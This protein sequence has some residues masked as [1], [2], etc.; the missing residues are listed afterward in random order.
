MC[1][2]VS[3]AVTGCDE[4]VIE[5][6][7]SPGGVYRPDQGCTVAEGAL[8]CPGPGETVPDLRFESAGNPGVL[9]D[10]SRG[11]LSNLRVTCG[12]SACGTGSLTAHAAL[13]WNTDP[14]LPQRAASFSHPFSPAPD[15]MGHTV[16]FSVYIEELTVPMHAQIGVIF[17]FWRWVAWAPLAKGW[18]RISG[19]V[20]PANILTKIDSSVTAIPVTSLQI[21]V[22]VPVNT[23]A[24]DNGA[25]SGE[26]YLDDIGWK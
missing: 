7:G 5:A 17:G 20:S 18:N 4:R 14:L 6:V 10:V 9:A 8:H 11:T 15:L 3:V 24:G 23:S 16:S 25:W 12:R 19:V 1:A 26:I 2:V 22:Y 13:S 21:D